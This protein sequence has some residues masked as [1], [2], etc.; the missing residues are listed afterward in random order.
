MLERQTI[1]TDVLVVWCVCQ[2]VS[3]YACTQTAE[4][5]RVSFGLET[6]RDPRNNERH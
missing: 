4:Q 2:S 3:L 5:I 6:L 1:A